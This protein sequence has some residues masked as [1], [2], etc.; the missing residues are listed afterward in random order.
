MSEGEKRERG[1]QWEEKERHGEILY[2]DSITIPS[3]ENIP[4]K[5]LAARGY[6]CTPTVQSAVP[7]DVEEKTTLNVK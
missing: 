1:R 7:A 6:D 4:P 5:P 2:K 3:S